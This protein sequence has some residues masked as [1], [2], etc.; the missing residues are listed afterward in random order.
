MILKAKHNCIIYPFFK[1]YAGFIIKRHYSTVRIIGE[2][3]DKNLPVLLL[4]NHIS[5]WDGF[6]AM[7]I[8]QKVLHRKF[9]FMML[10]KQLRKYWF[11]NY[12]GG[13][14]VHKSSKSMVE[15]LNYTS[16]LLTDKENMVLMYPQGEIQSLHH[17]NIRFERGVER[18]L[19]K[20][21]KGVQVVFMVNLID[22]FSNRKPGVYFHI[23]EYAG[24][25]FDLKS[26]EQSYREFYADAVRKQMTFNE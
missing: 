6:W 17:Q 4:S 8:N 20:K 13:F 11:F 16:D 14:S 21:E 7:Y 22:Y 12:T 24:G 1:W 19:R 9:H 3:K 26:M 23:R 25:T 2:F 5:W 18:V 15:T 10:E